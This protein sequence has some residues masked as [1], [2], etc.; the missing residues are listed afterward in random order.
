MTVMIFPR[1]FSLTTKVGE[2][3]KEKSFST[4]SQMFLQLRF[5]SRSSLSEKLIQVSVRLNLLNFQELSSV[6]MKGF[7]VQPLQ[8]WPPL[9]L[10]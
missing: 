8:L 10:K 9:C 7:N 6:H 3:N 5:Q 2:G 4:S 1:S